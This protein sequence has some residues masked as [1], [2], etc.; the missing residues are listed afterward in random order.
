MN[1]NNWY[2]G[3]LVDTPE[4]K[5]LNAAIGE[6]IY[7]FAGGTPMVLSSIPSISGGAISVTAGYAYLGTTTDPTY[8]A[9]T[10][11]NVL[12]AKVLTQ[13]GIVLVN[14]TCYVYVSAVI[15][16]NTGNTATAVTSSVYTSTNPAD[17][18]VKLADVVGGVITNIY[19]RAIPQ[20]SD[21]TGGVSSL[22]TLMG[23]LTLAAGSNI[24][25]TTSGGNTLTIASTASGGGGL[26][27]QLFTSSGT[28]TVPSGVTTIYVSASGGG[29]GGGGGSTT[30][31]GT[32]TNGSAGGA[33]SIGALLTLSGGLNGSA[34]L[35]GSGT[36]S[37]GGSSGGQGH[38]MVGA[39]GSQPVS[40][41][42][43]GNGGGTIFGSGG[44]PNNFGNTNGSGYGSG[45]AGGDTNI[46]GTC[47]GSG[48]GGA[49]AV[50]QTPLTVTPAQ[51]INIT[52]GT[53]GAGAGGTGFPGNGAPGFAL[54]QW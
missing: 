26:S 27:S 46:T 15:T 10:G 34:S 3:Q 21:I 37:A 48:G 43:G 12:G 38:P 4:M 42:V 1:F 47:G 8:I 11:T 29:G 53:G 33:T 2:F 51:I 14:P 40:P 6:C 52:I 25:I 23:A 19:T 32:G 5:V 22:N 50:L 17:D 24:T 16:P 9:D 31:G 30:A 44:N 41:G 18:G 7:G 49:A 54:I 35:G 39:G 13:S 20:E 28:F 36:P 45:G